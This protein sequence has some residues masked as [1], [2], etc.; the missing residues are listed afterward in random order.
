ASLG[1]NSRERSALRTPTRYRRCGKG[2]FDPVHR[3]LDVGQRG[4]GIESIR[5]GIGRIANGVVL[6]VLLVISCQ[7]ASEPTL[8]SERKRGGT[9]CVVRDD[10]LVEIGI[11][12]VAARQ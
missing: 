5:A 1:E 2:A 3:R 6:P 10:E 8:K 7:R 12:A 4:R 11:T 9:R